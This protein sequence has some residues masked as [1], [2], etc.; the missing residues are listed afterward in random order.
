MRL[1]AEVGN[2][3]KEIEKQRQTIKDFNRKN[4]TLEQKVCQLEVDLEN[5]RDK[6]K[7]SQD[8]WS[9]TRDALQEREEK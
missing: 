4:D 6:L 9:T 7:T 3:K 8:V 1:V 5:S 2:E